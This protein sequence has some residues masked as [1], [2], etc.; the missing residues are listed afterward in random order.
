MNEKWLEQLIRPGSSLGVAHPKATVVDEQGQLWIAKFPSKNDGNNTGA[1]EKVVHDLTRMCGLNVSE[2]QLETFS[3]PGS[4][5]LVKRFDRI[6]KKRI[7]FASAMTFLG[8]SD[9]AN[10]SDGTSY[11]DLAHF[12]KASL[13]YIHI[14]TPNKVL[15]NQQS[16]INL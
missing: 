16:I 9:G 2:S 7:H 8:K 11:L 13:D 12:I 15:V 6:E 10:A 14:S 5:F 4:T 1:L 3:K